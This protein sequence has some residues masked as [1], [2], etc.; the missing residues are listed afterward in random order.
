MFKTMN[1][2]LNTALPVKVS[3]FFESRA[4]ERRKCLNFY[5]SITFIII[6]PFYCIG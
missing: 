6:L 2:L 3:F 4:V 5:F 1:F